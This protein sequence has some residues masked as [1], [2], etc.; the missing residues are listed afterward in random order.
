MI[1][2]EKVSYA[3][4]SSGDILRDISFQ[5]PPGSLHFLTGAS[6]AGKSTLLKMIY[7]ASLPTSGTVKLFNKDVKKFN[8]S[9]LYRIRRKIGVVF[10]DFRLLDHLTAHENVALV[11]KVAGVRQHQIDSHVTELLKWVG[12]EDR[13]HHYPHNLSGGEKQRVAIARAVIGK[14]R[15]LVAD[16]PTGNLDDKLAMR[17]MRLFVELHR[18]G[19]SVVIATHSQQLVDE[20]KYPC[21]HLDNGGLEIIG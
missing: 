7:L 9:E 8:H 13:M 17:L 14:P 5:L 2:F 21:L 4:D 12:L 19:T 18:M 16:E 11:L 20:F 15:V 10:Q 6:G 3:Y 1:R